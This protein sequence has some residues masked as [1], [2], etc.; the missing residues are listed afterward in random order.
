MKFLSLLNSNGISF[1][2]I[3]VR[4]KMIP[5]SLFHNLDV[6]LVYSGI[7]VDVLVRRGAVLMT[8]DVLG[9]LGARCQTEIR[10]L[11]ITLVSINM[12]DI[13]YGPRSSMK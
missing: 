5:F 2:N 13:L 11:I 3:V 10:E 6:P 12:V 8:G 1:F 4:A 7:P 9:I